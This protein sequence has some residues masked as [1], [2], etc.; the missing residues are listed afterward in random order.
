M[1]HHPGLISRYMFLFRHSETKSGKILS[2]GW[3][4]KIFFP[5][6]IGQSN[7]VRRLSARLESSSTAIGSSISDI[8]AQ[9]VCLFARSFVHNWRTLLNPKS[10]TGVSRKFKGCL[11]LEGGFMD[12]LGMFEGVYRKVS[13]DFQRSLEM[14]QRVFQVDIKQCYKKVKC[15]SRG[16]LSHFQGFWE[17]SKRSFKEVLKGVLGQI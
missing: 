9:L 13:R 1:K 17:R 3:L 6:I 2:W 5:E 4:E 16:W 10:F 7:E 8:V 11:E 14:F 12:I 15:V